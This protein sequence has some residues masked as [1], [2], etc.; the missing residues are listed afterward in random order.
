MN[1]CSIRLTIDKATCWQPNPTNEIDLKFTSWRCQVAHMIK[2]LLD[3]T[4]WEKS[5]KPILGKKNLRAGQL[6]DLEEIE[7]KRCELKAEL[8]SRNCE[9]VLGNECLG[10]CS[11]CVKIPLLGLDKLYGRLA[12]E[13]CFRASKIPRYA[14]HRDK[15]SGDNMISFLYV[16]EKDLSAVCG[17]Y[18][19]PKGIVTCFYP[20]GK[21]RW[22]T[23]SEIIEHQRQRL[24]KQCQAKFVNDRGWLRGSLTTNLG[25]LLSEVL[26]KDH[27]SS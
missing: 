3:D 14:C 21:S 1:T 18:L 4:E 2:H 11:E 10:N 13:S 16:D 17:R 8:R 6:P 26:G 22:R 20:N 27:E 5:W 19:Q 25:K 7:R 9:T 12:I 24:E 23:A 15:K